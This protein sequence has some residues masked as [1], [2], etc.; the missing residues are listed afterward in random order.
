MS[1]MKDT[2]YKNINIIKASFS[3]I[4]QVPNN[5]KRAFVDVENK[6][7]IS[8]VYSIIS[9]VQKELVVIE[10]SSDS[11]NPL[12]EITST[13][14]DSIDYLNVLMNYDKITP[15]SEIMENGILTFL[16]KQNRF[17][18]TKELKQDDIFIIKHSDILVSLLPQTISLYIT[19]LKKNCE[20]STGL[21]RLHPNIENLLVVSS[22][23]KLHDDILLNN[24]MMKNLSEKS[25]KL[26]IFLSNKSFRYIDDDFYYAEL[27]NIR[28]ISD[29]FGYKQVRKDFK[30][31][32]EMFL[33]KKSNLPLLITSLPGLGKTH[34]TISNILSLNEL[35]LILPE[36]CELEKG[37]E[38]LIQ[39]L[40]NYKNHNFVIF[41]DDIDTRD[42]DWYYFRTN[43]GGSF[44]LPPNVNIIIASNYKYPPNILSRGRGV[45]FPIFDEIICQE[46]IADFLIAS[47]MKTTQQNLISVIAS[48]YVEEFAQKFFE[49]LSPRTLVRYLKQY[50]NN[51]DKRTKMLNASKEELITRPDSQIFFDLNIKLLKSLYGEDALEEIR[52]KEFSF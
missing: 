38:K 36:P 24:Q 48:D 31:H 28:D 2:I 44:V 20:N 7:G 13:E 18:K 40:H 33:N 5:N 12:I 16:T 32:F 8:T 9:A 27:N 37:L 41:F 21:L 10:K 42:I 23:F 46:M 26:D 39:K 30:M 14:P 15:I 51:Y 50:K 29:F 17:N 3:V 49:E 43:V 6:N 1:T 11:I 19:L 22:V 47:G 34:L 25:K 35:I 45:T 4:L 52:N